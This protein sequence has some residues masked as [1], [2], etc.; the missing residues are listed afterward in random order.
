MEALGRR[1]G[2][3]AHGFNSPPLTIPGNTR[4]VAAE[5][6]MPNMSGDDPARTL[7]RMCPDLPILMTC[8]CLRPADQQ[9]AV[10]IGVSDLI[11]NS[12]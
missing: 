1:A 12:Q 11:V 7:R 10:R 6:S 2:G 5:L 4:F 8:G 9:T 3:V